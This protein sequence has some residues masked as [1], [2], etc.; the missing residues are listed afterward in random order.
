MCVQSFAR[1]G[2]GGGD[3]MTSD[4]GL[5]RADAAGNRVYS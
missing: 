3:F 5:G 2:R 4:N 1:S